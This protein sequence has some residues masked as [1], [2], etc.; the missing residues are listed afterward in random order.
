[1]AITLLILFCILF[2]A[3]IFL[4][5]R[6]KVNHFK[7]SEFR[8]FLKTIAER[9]IT[10]GSMLSDEHKFYAPPLMRN[11]NFVHKIFT[12]TDGGFFLYIRCGDGDPVIQAISQERALSSRSV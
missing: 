12:S 5:H 6:N 11:R 10:L 3:G 2:A 9:K 1:M 7:Q 8:L 4:D